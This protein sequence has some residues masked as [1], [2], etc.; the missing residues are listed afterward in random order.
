[1]YLWNICIQHVLCVMY[2]KCMENVLEC[3]ANFRMYG[4]FV[5]CMEKCGNV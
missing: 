1:M 2:G 5:E 4:T 3:V